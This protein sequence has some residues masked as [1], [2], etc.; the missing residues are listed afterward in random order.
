VCGLSPLG[1]L[2]YATPGTVGVHSFDCILPDDYTARTLPPW[3]KRRHP[4]PCIFA[5]SLQVPD[6]VIEDWIQGGQLGDDFDDDM[7]DMDAD[8]WVSKGG[9]GWGGARAM[10]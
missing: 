4:L 3:C 1:F 6:E 2:S 10:P 5:P 7:D 8:G 9:V